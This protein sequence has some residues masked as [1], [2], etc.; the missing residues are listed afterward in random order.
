GPQNINFLRIAF[1]LFNKNT[2]FTTLSYLFFGRRCTK[3]DNRACSGGL[4][5]HVNRS[6]PTI[7]KLLIR[8]S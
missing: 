8:I 6:I 1:F 4:K 3:T 5:F 2:P 7:V